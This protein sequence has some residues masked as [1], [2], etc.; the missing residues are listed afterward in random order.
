MNLCVNKSDVARKK[1]LIR[2][3]ADEGNC[4][5]TFGTMTVQVLPT[6]LSFIGRDRLG[7]SL[8][9]SLLRSMPWLIAPEP[10]NEGRV[11]LKHNDT[12]RHDAAW[13]WE[14][15]LTPKG[16]EICHKAFEAVVC[17]N[18]TFSHTEVDNHHVTQVTRRANEPGGR[19]YYIKRRLRNWL[20][21]R[22]RRTRCL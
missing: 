10:T 16:E 8:L 9:H 1:I 21:Q 2:H 6:A 14:T 11:T 20:E 15:L 17:D 12:R 4:V 22:H 13:K 18:Y 3:F 7:Y 5:H 19:R